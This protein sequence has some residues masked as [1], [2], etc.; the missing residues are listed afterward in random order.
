MADALSSEGSSRLVSAGSNPVPG[1]N[2]LGK[3]PPSGKMC[4]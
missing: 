1:T 2:I 4:V 3:K